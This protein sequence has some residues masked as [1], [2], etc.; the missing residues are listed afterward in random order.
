MLEPS[1]SACSCSSTRLT[2]RAQNALPGNPHAQFA[3]LCVPIPCWPRL[4][5]LALLKRNLLPFSLPSSFQYHTVLVIILGLSKCKP[6]PCACPNVSSRQNVVL[7]AFLLAS[8]TSSCSAESD[9]KCMPELFSVRTLG[10]FTVATHLWFT[11]SRA[12]SVTHE[13]TRP[14][15]SSEHHTSRVQA[16]ARLHTLFCLKR[17]LSSSDAYSMSHLQALALQGARRVVQTS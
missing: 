10:L 4:S 5:C 14:A 1:Q 3:A 12:R 7:Q 11:P 9:L 2:H 6:L 15:S 13:G 16:L 17:M 8:N